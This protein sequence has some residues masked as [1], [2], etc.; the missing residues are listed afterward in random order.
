MEPKLARPKSLTDL[1]AEHIREA[2]VDARLKLGEQL[3]E[4]ALAS[5]L[6]I[7]KTPVREALLRL[8]LDGLVDVHPQRGTFVFRLSQDDV[9]EICRFREILEGAALAEAMA[10]D[11][12]A[13]V[14]RLEANIAA[15]R[16]AQRSRNARELPRLDAEFH[17]AIL[18]LCGNSYLRAAYGLIEHKIHALRW[19]LPEDS[20]Q[21]T[22]C[23]HNHAVII[24][25]IRQGNVGKAQTTLKRHIRDTLDAY[26]EASSARAE[27][28]RDG[29]RIDMRSA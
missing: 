3:S 1:A 22:H 4:S 14:R 7:S 2:I 6:G 24:G 21:I 28:V 5:R 26:L 11:R 17:A 10:R 27:T 20:D 25:Q 12:D 13:L 19:R 29:A 9:V 15:M 8:K 18:E 16:R 23:Q